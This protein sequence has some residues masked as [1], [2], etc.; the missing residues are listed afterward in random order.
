MRPFQDLPIRRKLL[1]MTL[2]VSTT[3]VLVAMVGFVGYDVVRTRA[4]ITRD[5]DAQARIIAENSAAPLTFTDDVAAGETLA[6]RVGY[7]GAAGEEATVK[8]R[9]LYIAVERA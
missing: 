3:A 1:L 5:M 6:V 4:E 9:P 8:G 7:D 2:A